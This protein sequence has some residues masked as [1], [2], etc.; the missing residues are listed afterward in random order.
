M[1]ELKI[2]I[3]GGGSSYTP[4]LIEGL[5]NRATELPLRELWMVDIELGR[6]KMAIIASLARRMLK[7]AGLQVSV[8]ETLDRHA[9]LAGAD[10]VCSQFRAGCLAARIS[11]ERISLKYG[12]IGQETNGLGGFANACRTIPVALEIAREMEQLC[13]DAWL[14]NFTN[15]SGMVT[16][17]ILRHS[18]IKA[19]GLCNVPVIMQKG[20]SQLLGNKNDFILQ[21]AGLNHFIFARQILQNGKDKLNEVIDEIVAGNDPLVPRN[22][23]PFT[24][25]AHV[26]KGLGMIPCA[27]LRYYY[28]KDDILKQE[29]GEANGEGTRGEV[30]KALEHQLF[31]IYKNPD[32]AEKPKALEGRGGQ[33]YSEAA[34]ELMSAIHND[35]RI[36][37]HVNTLNNGAINGLPDDCVVE[38]SSLITRSGPLPLNVATFPQDT[39][40]LL[41]LMKN[42]EQLTIEAAITGDRHTAWRALV[43][44]PLITSGSLLEEALSEVI[45][46]NKILLKAFH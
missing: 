19:V 40:R 35:K 6:E 7:K 39:L 13:P 33:Y 41:Q 22:I 28:M 18:S 36:I 32:L 3:I 12:M 14:L 9:A 16:E 1:S 11:D 21:V 37:M 15:P 38:V 31:E 20:V 43:L 44:N 2:V 46:K 10:Y 30:V 25:P 27:Y 34:C 24:W 4:E 17:A 5:I 29:I 8:H 26:L 45:E 23:P 42:F